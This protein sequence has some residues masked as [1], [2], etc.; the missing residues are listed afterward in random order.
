VVPELVR[1]RDDFAWPDDITQ[2]IDIDPV[3]L[4]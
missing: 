1:L 4:I 2:V 3:N